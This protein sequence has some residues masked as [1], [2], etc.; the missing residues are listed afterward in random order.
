MTTIDAG[1]FFAEHPYVPMHLG[2]LALFEGPAP[3]YHDLVGLY[4]ARLSLVPRYRQVVRTAPLHMLRPAWT[5]DE[6]FE[7]GNHVRHAAVPKP[8]RAPQLHR[9]AG[10]LYAQ[11]LD[12]GRPLWEA[13]L[14]DGLADERWAILFKV[15]H[16]MADG[17]GGVDLLAEIFDLQPDAERR[18][19]P[20]GWHPRPEPSLACALVSGLGNAVMLPLR[21][22][23]AVPGLLGR[24]LP[25]VN[26]L[27]EFARGL[28]GSA[29][30]L[31]V[32]AAS[33]LNGPIGPG[34]R[35]ACTTA[36]LNV[37][38][39]IRAEHGGSVNDVLLAAITR[40]FRDLL[41]ERRELS[42]GLTVRSLVPISIRRPDERGVTTNRLSAVLANLPVAESDPIR[43]LQL[44]REQ[45]QQI[46]QTNQA[47]G[48]D[49]LTQLLG[50]TPPTLLRLGARAAFQLP[51]SLVQTMTTNVPGPGFP[52]YVLGRKMVHVHPYA[53]I[54]DNVRIAVAMFSYLDEISFG[55]T[56]DSSAASDVRVLAQGI[57][58]GLAELQP[59]RN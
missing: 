46:M 29:R 25:G 28:T 49:L 37:V 43:R 44:V 30:R 3:S 6:D 56:A 47:A 5:D 7:L 58:R 8:G 16:C 9:L 36:G 33:C 26:D 24:R 1:F 2:A 53:P 23:V 14:L 22:L 21:V 39:Q 20:H 57:R 18:D 55:I 4:A 11:P 54:G 34:R 15:H 51:Q 17:I 42:E 32:P 40:G 59:A 12:Q 45:M 50:F 52:L 31:M 35:W 38:R 19:Q 27:A 13:W 48:A 10:E 41:I